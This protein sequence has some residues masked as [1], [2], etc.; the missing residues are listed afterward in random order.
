MKKQQFNLL[1][2][3][4]NL[5]E[6]ISTKDQAR[7]T[8]YLELQKK[9]ADKLK[10]MQAAAWPL[11]KQVARS[12]LDEILQEIAKMDQEIG[13]FGSAVSSGAA[14]ESTAS[15]EKASSVA[16]ASGGSVDVAGVTDVIG[17]ENY[18]KMSLDELIKLKALKENTI[19]K[20]TW[21]AQKHWKKIEI[22]E[23]QDAIEKLK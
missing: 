23:V 4:S 17:K 9:R 6:K 21:P 5:E 19:E 16:N 15:E 14:V 12:E 1:E 20:L 13:F 22:Q 10:E 2:S 7:A 8:K 11:Q 3:G 18:A